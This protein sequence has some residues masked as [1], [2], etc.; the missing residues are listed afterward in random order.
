MLTNG[1]GRLE[2]HVVLMHVQFSLSLHGA[3]V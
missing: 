2:K 1:D 3:D